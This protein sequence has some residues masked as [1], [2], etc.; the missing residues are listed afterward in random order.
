VAATPISKMTPA[1]HHPAELPM[2][3]T[4]EHELAKKPIA[5]ANAIAGPAVDRPAKRAAP[6]RRVVKKPAKKL[7][8]GWDPE[9]I[10]PP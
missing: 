4:P 1:P 3:E 2:P 8:P 10:L 5:G 7:P 9:S 6:P